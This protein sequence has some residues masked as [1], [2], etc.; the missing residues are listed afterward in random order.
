M[1]HTVSAVPTG[2]WWWCQSHL[3]CSPLVFWLLKKVVEV[4]ATPVRGI[5]EGCREVGEEGHLL[6]SIS[7]GPWHVWSIQT[8][9]GIGLPF[10]TL[11]QLVRAVTCITSS[12]PL[13]FW[14]VNTDLLVTNTHKNRRS[15][16]AAA[17]IGLLEMFPTN[18]SYYPYN[19][20]SLFPANHEIAD[21]ATRNWTHLTSFPFSPSCSCISYGILMSFRC[22][23]AFMIQ[24]L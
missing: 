2:G 20:S 19:L 7:S 13:T 3:G 24:R 21:S 8:K 4:V 10:L 5:L 11:R 17:E 16:D 6:R 23:C 22:I 14:S 9:N 12:L 18:L 15:S 1:L